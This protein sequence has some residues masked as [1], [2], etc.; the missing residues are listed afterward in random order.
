[1]YSSDSYV[2]VHMDLFLFYKNICDKWLVHNNVY[3]YVDMLVK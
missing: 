1:M 2:Y 3:I